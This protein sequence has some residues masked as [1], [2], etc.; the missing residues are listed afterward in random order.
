MLVNG[1]LDVVWPRLK[2][3]REYR[4]QDGWT[5]NNNQTFTIPVTGQSARGFLLVEATV[6]QVAANSSSERVARVRGRITNYSTGNFY[7][8]V[9]EGDTMA[10]QAFETY[11]VGT[12]GSASGTFTMKYHPLAGYQQSVVCR[13]YL[14]ILIG[15]Y[16]ISLGAL[17][18]A[19]TGSNVA[20]AEPTFEPQPLQRVIKY[21][22][23]LNMTSGTWHDIGD[24]GSPA[25]VNGAYLLTVRWGNSNNST[26][27]Y[28]GASGIIY[29]RGDGLAVYN[30]QG[31]EEL[32]LNHW[33]HYRAVAQFEFKLDSD[34]SATSY[35]NTT[36]YVK[37]QSATTITFT[38]YMTLLQNV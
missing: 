37:G 9:M 19:D 6:I 14:K 18:R 25:M 16:T 28:G 33:Y 27:W 30:A 35:G 34:N 8:T 20:L 7:M 17:T 24:F 4:Y 3:E 12:S 2:Y 36:L 32:R 22:A 23:S 26:T 1:M 29:I 15:G 10:A 13:L 31:P 11:I 21:N 5:G 38:T